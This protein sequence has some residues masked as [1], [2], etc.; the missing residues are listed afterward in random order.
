[1]KA[2]LRTSTFDSWLGELRNR[3]SVGRIT[4]AISKLAQGLGDVKPVGEGVSE[5]RLPFGPGFRIYFTERGG[6]VIALL[7]GGDKSTQAK[8]IR[9]AKE[10]KRE[11][12]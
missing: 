9:K 7:C 1:M 2:V 8:D 10:L 5:L 12:K 6:A 3:V 11:L 4:T